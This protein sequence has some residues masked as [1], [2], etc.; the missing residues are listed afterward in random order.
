M[1][2][3]LQRLNTFIRQELSELIHRRL[4]DPRLAEFVSITRVDVSADLETAAVYVSIMGT[5]EDKKAT[6]AV[7]AAAGPYLRRE[8]MQVLT[9]RRVPTL[10]FYLDE[11]I[12][13][14]ARLLDIINKVSREQSD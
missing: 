2:R 6:M 9:I 4:K 1:S 12:E 13:E 8:L 7:L 11:T 3:R 10:V 5:E 14:G